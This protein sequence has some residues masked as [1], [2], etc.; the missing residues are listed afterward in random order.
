MK[1]VQMNFKCTDLKTLIKF[2]VW[3]EQPLNSLVADLV[4]SSWP[5]AMMLHIK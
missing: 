3:H 5:W 4:L 1:N 2:C